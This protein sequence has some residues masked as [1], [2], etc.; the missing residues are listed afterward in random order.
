MFGYVLPCKGRL[1]DEEFTRY[2]GAYC[3]LCQGLQRGYGFLARF[4]VNYDM[5]FLYF[6]LQKE[7][8]A[9]LESCFC[10][11]RPFCKRQCMPDSEAMAYVAD[12]TVLLSYHKLRDAVADSRGFKRLGARLALLLYRPAYKKAAALRTGED[13]SFRKELDRLAEYE[14]RGCGSIDRAA[15][16]FATL[17]QACALFEEDATRRRVLQLLLYHVGRFL[18]LAD[19][20][21]DLPKDL[22]EGSYNP[23]ALRFTLSEGKL[24]EEDLEALKDTMEASVDMAA[25]ALELLNTGAN[26]KLLENIVYYGLPAVLKSVSTGT[27]RKRRSKHEGSL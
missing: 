11:A 12:V 20:L 10:P 22:K 27:F 25:S 18:Y 17:L 23:L 14:T 24:S 21:E 6:L 26:R 9:C 2:K 3:G 19:A 5:T 4:L 8:E 1:S 15:D 7:Q 16:P 13:A